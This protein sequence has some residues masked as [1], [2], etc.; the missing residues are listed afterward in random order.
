M[1]IPDQSFEC[2]LCGM[3]LTGGTAVWPPA[4]GPDRDPFCGQDCVALARAV[5]HSIPPRVDR[6]VKRDHSL[7]GVDPCSD[8]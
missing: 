2:T 4:G 8:C 5:E 7:C 6:A 3:P 1:S